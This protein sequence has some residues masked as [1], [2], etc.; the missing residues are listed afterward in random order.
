MI[1]ASLIAFAVGG[2]F[3]S[4]A[5]YPH[6]YVLMGIFTAS[7]F[8]FERLAENLSPVIEETV[9]YKA[10]PKRSIWNTKK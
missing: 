8:V 3:L 10:K 9:W 2:A 5:Y 7:H 1:N 6:L 4:V